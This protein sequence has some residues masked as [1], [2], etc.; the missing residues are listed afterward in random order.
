MCNN[1]RKLKHREEIKLL[2]SV[3]DIILV[4][5][6]GITGKIFSKAGLLSSM[7]FVDKTRLATVCHLTLFFAHCHNV[8]QTKSLSHVMENLFS[9]ENLLKSTFKRVTNY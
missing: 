6:E 4:T 2:P 7:L 1:T 5:L 3:F 8:H 9:V